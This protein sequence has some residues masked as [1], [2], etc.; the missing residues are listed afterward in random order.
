LGYFGFEEAAKKYVD[1][2]FD[3]IEEQLPIRKHKPAPEYFEKYGNEMKY[4]VIRKNKKNA[5]VH[6]F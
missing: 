3:E 5:L 2:I 1:G 6:I 4:I